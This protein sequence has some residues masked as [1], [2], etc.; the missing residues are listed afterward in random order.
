MLGGSHFDEY[1]L[2]YN[3]VL[4]M[5]SSFGQP[6]GFLGD[7]EPP[8]GMLCHASDQPLGPTLANSKEHKKKAAGAQSSSPSPS[9]S[10]PDQHQHQALTG[11]HPITHPAGEIAMLFPGER[12]DAAR[13]EA[14]Y[15]DQVLARSHVDPK[16]RGWI[17]GLHAGKKP[18]WDK[19]RKS[20]TV[21]ISTLARLRFASKNRFKIPC[22]CFG[23][24]R[25]R[26]SVQNF[27]A[28]H[29]AKRDV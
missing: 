14:C 22:V 26:T 29:W 1:V 23:W 5:P 9:P 24:I 12:A 10:V 19:G 8:M 2:D 25:E 4:A 27:A 20:E 13:A 15:W 21:R 6:A 18:F 17:C 3:S 11:A 7:F 16:P 28:C